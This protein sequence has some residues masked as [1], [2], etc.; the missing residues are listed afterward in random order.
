[1]KDSCE[2]NLRLSMLG[3]KDNGLKRIS[4]I[5]A[6]MDA[7]TWIGLNNRL[8]PVKLSILNKVPWPTE[9]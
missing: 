5:S 8:S 4:A 1:M 7:F 2:P 6:N 3:A 9:E